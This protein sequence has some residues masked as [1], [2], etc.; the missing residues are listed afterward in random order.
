MCLNDYDYRL[1]FAAVQPNYSRPHN[2][3]DIRKI[4]NAPIAACPMINP[5]MNNPTRLR[6]RFDPPTFNLHIRPQH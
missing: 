4:S 2:L 5:T 1:S 3:F 6:F